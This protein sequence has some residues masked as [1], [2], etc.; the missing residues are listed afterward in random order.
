MKCMAAVTL[1]IAPVV[2][3]LQLHRAAWGLMFDEG[4]FTQLVESRTKITI[5]EIRV[6][7]TCC[8]MS[9]VFF[10]QSCDIFNLP[11]CGNPRIPN[12]PQTHG[13]FVQQ[14]FISWTA[15]TCLWMTWRTWKRAVPKDPTR[16][17]SLQPQMVQGCLAQVG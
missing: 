7:Y 15:R 13:S 4:H 2:F 1:A 5:V 17:S 12:W 9:S 10:E 14:K 6:S 8:W 16:A 3:W 11:W